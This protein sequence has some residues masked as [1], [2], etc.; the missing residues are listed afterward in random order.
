M[1]E[2]NNNEGDGGVNQR[3]PLS[4]SFA[5]PNTDTDDR[6][7]GG[8]EA[9]HPHG[10][11]FNAPVPNVF[12]RYTVHTYQDYS[13]FIKEGG[14]ITKHKKSNRNFPAR[15]HAILSND[16]YS[17][18]ISWR[19]S[20]PINTYQVQHDIISLISIHYSILCLLWC[21]PH[22]R[23]FL[24]FFLLLSHMVV[25]GRSTK[26]IYWFETS[27]QNISVSHITRLLPD[28]WMDGVSKGSIRRVQV[29]FSMCAF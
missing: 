5:P 12:P 17:H 25:P 13:T 4:S 8:A 20:N 27:F 11:N 10:S 26:R 18:I 1:A 16:Q 14:V 2:R 6:G 15:L 22:T 7:R 3:E 19:V 24:S 9:E 28:S 23:I 29:S 21:N